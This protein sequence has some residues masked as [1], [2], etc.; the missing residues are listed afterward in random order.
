MSKNL[1][2]FLHTFKILTQYEIQGMIL[3]KDKYLVE[4][5][6]NIKKNKKKKKK[7]NSQVQ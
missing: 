6:W 4:S 7:K 3:Q 1:S 5:Y 2:P